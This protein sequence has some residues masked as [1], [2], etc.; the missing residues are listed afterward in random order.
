MSQQTFAQR[1]AGLT[2]ILAAF[3]ALLLV[4]SIV[5]AISQQRG[6]KT[7]TADFPQVNALYEGSAV[8]ILGVPVGTV[9]DLEPRG[10][11]VRVTISYDEDVK[12]P[13]DVRAVVV[14]PAIVGDR[15]VQLAPAFDGGAALKDGA[16]LPLERTEVP[17]ELDT[18]YQSL[19]D[20]AVALGPDGANADG[21]LSD[22]IDSTAAQ[23]D[24]EGAQLNQTI[25]D[26]GK[27]STTL[28]NNSDE[29]FS[30]VTQVNEFVDLLRANDSTVR[31]FNASTAELS[32][33]L[34]EERDDLEEALRLLSL[35]L[36]DVN[37]LVKE[38]RGELR[39][40]VENLRVLSQTLADNSEG[41][42]EAS[43]AAPT[44]LANVAL[45]Y[46]PATGTLDNHSN[47]PGQLLGNVTDPGQLLCNLAEL[48]EDDALCQQL[49]GLLDIIP[50]DELLGGLL[51][52][53]AA[54]GVAQGP[55]SGSLTELMGVQ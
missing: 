19:D 13:D 18:I 44:A 16:A 33:V 32:V 26:F 1:F 4:G 12:L 15:F 17:V 51:R 3:V 27:L 50:L 55:Q 42:E 30:S 41:L 14:S 10:E 36:V 38:N 28:D 35:A 39:D 49:T 43:I 48:T 45:A 29:L 37:T 46:N 52:P 7:L 2:K 24:G 23:L 9:E 25:R 34:D 53:T 31:A 22:L 5:L 11:I 21:A 47:L 40:N 8:K 54:S 6:T 20:L